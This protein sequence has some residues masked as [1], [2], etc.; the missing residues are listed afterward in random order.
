MFFF[1]NRSDSSLNSWPGLFT[2][3]TPKRIQRG[4]DAQSR[5]MMEEGEERVY[6]AI[7]SIHPDHGIHCCVAGHP[8][9][10][11]FGNMFDW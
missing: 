2:T 6:V 4:Y 11:I 5:Q 3:S 7:S 1:C 9:H 10:L 8:V